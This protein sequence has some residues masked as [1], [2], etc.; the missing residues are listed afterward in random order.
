MN[1]WADFCFYGHPLEVDAMT[2]KAH[3]T[4]SQPGQKLRQERQARA[5][6]T[7]R[8]GGPGDDWEVD[9]P[10]DK[11]QTSAGVTQAAGSQTDAI[12]AVLSAN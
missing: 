8:P 11:S 3:T 6:R 4:Q 7:R 1:E 10:L 9:F 5:V 12:D 2:L